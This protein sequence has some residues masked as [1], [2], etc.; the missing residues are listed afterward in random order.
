[1]PSGRHL[2]SDTSAPRNLAG[3]TSAMNIGLTS[4]R[5]RKALDV[6]LYDMSYELAVAI[7]TEPMAKVHDDTNSVGLR[8]TLSAI[9]P[10]QR[11]HHG[12][13]IAAA[14]ARWWLVRSNS[15]WTNG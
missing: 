4:M 8:P 12:E 3:D 9:S 13:F 10:D 11:A 2:P 15:S 14:N 5:R 7:M 6:R 1:M